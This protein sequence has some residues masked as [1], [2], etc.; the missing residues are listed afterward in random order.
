MFGVFR[1]SGSVCL[2]MAM[3]LTAGAVMLITLFSSADE[4]KKC[5]D[6]KELPVLMYHSVVRDGCETGEYVISE[7][8]LEA[9]LMWLGE[10]GY[11]T[12]FCSDAEGFVSEGAPLP[13]KPV[14]LTFDDGC[15]NS[16]SIV[17]PLLEK[18]GMKGTF[19]PVGEWCI[20]SA[21]ETAPSEVW[22]YMKPENLRTLIQS[23]RCELASHSW[24]MHDLGERQGMLR[25]EGESFT[26]YRRTLW[27]DL[28]KEQKLFAECGCKGCKVL[29]YPY[30][31]G[32]E[33]TEQL[34]AEMGYT[35]TLS[36]R[37]RMNVLRNNDRSCLRLMGRFERTPERSAADILGADAE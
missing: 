11:T 14:I 33:E 4:G 1:L 27:G 19:A 21:E 18:Y 31:F 15:Y 25:K 6:G 32:N 29:V 10:N 9:D 35:V 8:A 24:S 16:F 22:S 20:N 37:E 34:T 28:H 7:S 30:G 2:A 26:D 13:E 12:V 23:G 36:C 5:V 17:L 3:G